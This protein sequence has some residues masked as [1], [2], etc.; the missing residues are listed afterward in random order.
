MVCAFGISRAGIDFGA[1][2]GKPS[3]FFAMVL[4]P[5]NASTEYTRL[6]GALARALDTDGR[7]ALLATRSSQDALAIL[8]ARCGTHP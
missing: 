4:M 3:H 5:P 7:A 1:M 8:T 2:D 6:I